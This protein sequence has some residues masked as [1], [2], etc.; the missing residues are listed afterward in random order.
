MP[1]GTCSGTIWGASAVLPWSASKIL[2]RA[3]PISPSSSLSISLDRHSG[4][5]SAS[6]T[7]QRI[8]T[9]GW[10]VSGSRAIAPAVRRPSSS[11]LAAGKT[12]V[13]RTACRWARLASSARPVAGLRAASSTS[14]SPGRKCRR[15]SSS[16]SSVAWVAPLGKQQFSSLQV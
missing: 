2:P 12:A 16:S 11:S 5:D 9:M 6:S 15:F 13:S 8:S 1:A 14:T 3:M 4:K 7:C 10:S